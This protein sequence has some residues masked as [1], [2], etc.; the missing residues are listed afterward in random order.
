MDKRR[1]GVAATIYTQRI[2]N[3]L[4]TDINLHNEKYPPIDVHIASNVHDRF[5]IVDDIVY[6]IGA[7]IKDLGKK[8]FAFSRMNEKP[9]NL[10]SRLI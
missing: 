9:Q 4:Q 8:I 6:H 3:A 1:A 7:S 2:S 5:L 10:L